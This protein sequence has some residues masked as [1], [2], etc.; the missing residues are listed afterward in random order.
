MRT[1]GLA[2]RLVL[3]AVIATLV[4][5][6]FQLTKADTSSGHIEAKWRGR[7]REPDEGVEVR[8]WG[9]DDEV[10]VTMKAEVIATLTSGPRRPTSLS[11]FFSALDGRIGEHALVDEHA[12]TAPSYSPGLVEDLAQRWSHHTIRYPIA[13]AL[14]NALFLVLSGTMG[15]FVF[16]D[17]LLPLCVIAISIPLIM[18]ATLMAS[19]RPRLGGMVASIGGMLSLPLGVLGIMAALWAFRIHEQ[20]VIQDRGILFGGLG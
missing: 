13:L 4:D 11:T 10:N 18:G 1:Y 2:R 16:E 5:E 9:P 8:V 15:L 20:R 19:G 7:G 14:A 12:E 6:G 17:P 3:K